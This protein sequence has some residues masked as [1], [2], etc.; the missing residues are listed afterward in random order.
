MKH[1][2]LSKLWTPTFLFA[3]LMGCQGPTQ[4]PHASTATVGGLEFVKVPAGEFLMGSG[5]FD[6]STPVHKVS[7]SSFWMMTKEVTNAQFGKFKPGWKRG[8]HSPEDDQPVT[9]VSPADIRNY[10]AWLG[11]KTGR[12]FSL[13]TEAQWE[14]AARGGLEGRDY[15]WGNESPQGHSHSGVLMTQKVGSY[16][17]NKFG[18]FDMAGNVGEMVLEGPYRYRRTPSRDPQGPI[19]KDMYLY[20]G[21]GPSDPDPYLWM[22]NIGVSSIPTGDVGFRLVLVEPGK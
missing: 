22:R 14:Y 12:R 21:A 4:H 20:R 16:P 2:S 7:L 18:L 8:E 6:D 1:S 17:A 10:C 9:M 5:K 3:P 19:A 15:P 13:P 11:L